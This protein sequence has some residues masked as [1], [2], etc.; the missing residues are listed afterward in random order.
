MRHI[1]NWHSRAC[2]GRAYPL[3]KYRMDY[4]VFLQL[5]LCWHK[6]FFDRKLKLSCSVWYIISVSPHFWILIH[7]LSIPTFLDLLELPFFI[8]KF[9]SQNLCSTGNPC[10]LGIS[11]GGCMPW[12]S[13]SLTTPPPTSYPMAPFAFLLVAVPSLFSMLLLSALLQPKCGHSPLL[14]SLT[15]L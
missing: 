5:V 6:L 7:N 4:A 15:H 10:P 11:E 14:Y 2:Q 12:C 3:I 13:V 8:P 9:N 1:W